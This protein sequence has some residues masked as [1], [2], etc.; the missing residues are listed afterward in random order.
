MYTALVIINTIIRENI[1]VRETVSCHLHDLMM[2]EADL[3]SGSETSLLWISIF[4]E[5]LG[6]VR[7]TNRSVFRKRRHNILL[8]IYTFLPP[9][10]PFHFPFF[11][12]AIFFLYFSLP[13]FPV[14]LPFL[15]LLLKS[16]PKALKH[17]T[18]PHREG[19]RTLLIYK[20]YTPLP[21]LMSSAL[22]WDEKY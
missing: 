9:Y 2:K 22:E 19:C 1:F 21:G 15:P 4:F 8:I 17:P 6:P 14:F 5:R 11:L 10:T 20:Q 3:M 12:P 16:F 13:L 7:K 18:H